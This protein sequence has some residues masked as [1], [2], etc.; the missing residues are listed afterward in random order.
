MSEEVNLDEVMSRRFDLDEQITAIQ[1]KNKTDLAPLLEELQLC[2]SYIKAELIK[3][4][5]QQWK[6]SAT[7]HMTYWTTKD[8]VTVEDMDQVIHR[9][10]AESPLPPKAPDSVYA[11]S[12]DRWEAIL[13]HI[14]E[15]GLWALLNKAVNKTT[16]REVLESGGE[17]PGVKLTSFRD[18]AWRR[19]KV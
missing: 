6:S 13:N 14:A 9:I 4:G 16:T 7:G 12:P 17:V 3:T 5:A 11:M 10:L 19:G 2:E 18:L 15:T 8:S 1:N